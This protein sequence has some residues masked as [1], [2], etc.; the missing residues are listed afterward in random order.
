ME[1]SSDSRSRQL[2]PHTGRNPELGG[3]PLNVVESDCLGIGGR[4][5]IVS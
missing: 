5:A 4:F 2:R 1:L 3:P